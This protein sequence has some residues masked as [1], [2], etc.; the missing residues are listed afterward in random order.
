MIQ[1]RYILRPVIH[2]AIFALERQAGEPGQHRFRARADEPAVVGCRQG[3]CQ[4]LAQYGVPVLCSGTFRH[5]RRAF[6]RLA[7]ALKFS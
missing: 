3:S 1:D 7:G 6:V 2:E 4:L 5:L